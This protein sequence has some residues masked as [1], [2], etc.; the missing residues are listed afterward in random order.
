MT[1]KCHACDE[2]VP[3]DHE[4]ACPLCGKEK[5]YASVGVI[6]ET[7]NVGDF[8]SVE[9]KA[10]Q[11]ALND[12]YARYD[13][14]EK[15]YAGKIESLQ[16]IKKKRASLEKQEKSLMETA[17][18][19]AKKDYKKSKES[20]LQTKT[21]TVGAI[22]GTPEQQRIFELEKKLQAQNI[23][24]DALSRIESD[25]SEIKVKLS[26]KQ[27]IALGATA[28]FIGSIMFGV[29]TYVGTVVQENPI[30]VNGTLP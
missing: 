30:I 3:Q 11:N 20:F 14:L 1:K 18:E 23:V 10:M 7:V 4:G 9:K 13:E 17:E 15:Q 19:N 21:F 27:T 22:I 6:N 16:N 5:G 28:S 29:W 8:I 25:I 2:E 26:I 12:A 24:T